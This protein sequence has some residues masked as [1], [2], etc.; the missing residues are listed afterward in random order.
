MITL[1]VFLNFLPMVLAGLVFHGVSR[2]IRSFLAALR[3]VKPPAPL[4]WLRIA[5][6][7][8]QWI[9]PSRYRSEFFGDL[10]EEYIRIKEALGPVKAKRW[11]RKQVLLSIIPLL[12]WRLGKMYD[13]LRS[14][15]SVGRAI[16]IGLCIYLLPALL[17]VF[18]VSIIGIVICFFVDIMR[19]FPPLGGLFHGLAIIIRSLVNAT[20]WM[21]RS[22]GLSR[23]TGC[24]IRLPLFA[25]LFRVRDG[26]PTY[27]V[28]ERQ[29]VAQGTSVRGINLL[30]N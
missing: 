17:A 7:L 3:R 19:R 28:R 2:V 13:I 16:H 20:R 30:S 18:L 9:V 5:L 21:K 11:V 26:G 12:R 6:L 22:T 15:E 4:T 10:R 24:V 8:L 25:S 29:L 27:F 23:F 1:V 14:E